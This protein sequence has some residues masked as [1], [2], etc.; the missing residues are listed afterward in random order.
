[1][2][3]ETKLYLNDILTCIERIQ[4]YTDS[5][6]FEEFS[7]D[8]RTNDAVVR[9]LEIIGEA[10]KNIPPELRSKYGYDWRSI[11]GLRDILIY[12]YFGVSKNIVW[13]IIQNELPALE[14]K[15]REILK[16]EGL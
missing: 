1:M 16:N 14:Q 7:A 5:L 2:Y 15:I 6:S 8:N 10:A 13:D 11:A 9:N 4:E 12:E 3:R